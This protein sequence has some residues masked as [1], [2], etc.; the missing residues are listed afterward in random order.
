MFT[1]DK[2]FDM[3]NSAMPADAV[4]IHDPACFILK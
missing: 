4:D 1:S 3:V 2:P